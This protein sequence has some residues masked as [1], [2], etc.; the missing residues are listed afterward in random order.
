MKLLVRPE[1]AADIEDACRWYRQQRRDLASEFLDSVRVGIEKILENPEGYPVMHRET[2]RIRI[3]RF[4]YGLF[5]RI[6]ADT[7]VVVACM[8]GRRDPIQWRQR[9]GREP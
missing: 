3:K 4:P 9:T 6:Y 7:V 8:H 2:R 5:Y 1:A